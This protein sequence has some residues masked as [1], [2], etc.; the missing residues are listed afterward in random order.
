MRIAATHSEVT[1]RIIGAC[2]E[3]HRE[4]GPGLLESAYEPCLAHEMT[5]RGIR[6]ERQRRVPLVYKGLQVPGGYRLDFVV[7]RCVVV[8]MKAVAQLLPVH[9]AQVLTYLRLTGIPVG[10][11]VN[12]HVPKIR[13]GGLRRL[14]WSAP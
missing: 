11:L 7:E 9:E 8:E 4:L 12:F 6:F 2:I 3:V 13:A 14:V 5:L 10:L 1:E